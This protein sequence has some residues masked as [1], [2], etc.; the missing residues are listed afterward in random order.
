[1]ITSFICS[2]PT[3]PIL[4]FNWLMALFWSSLVRAVKFYLGREGA[5]WLQIMAL[6]LAGLPTTTTFTLRLATL[7]RVAP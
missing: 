6:V 1:M 2:T 3:F 7:S 4:S 5:K